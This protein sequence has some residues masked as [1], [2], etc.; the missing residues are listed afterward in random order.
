VFSTT[1]VVCIG[2][3]L[4]V[5]AASMPAPRR[6][7]ALG[8][9][10]WLLVA[11]GLGAFLVAT[12]IEHGGWVAKGTPAERAKYVV[13]RLKAPKEKNILLIDGG[14]YAARGVSERALQ[15]A[16]RKL[17]Y[18]V[19]VVHM[20]MGA[21][22]HFERQ[23]LYRRIVSQLGPRT[24]KK[25]RWIYLAEVHKQY[26]S[27][28]LAQFTPNAD[29]ARAE[30]YMTPAAAWSALNALNSE[31]I[32]K[33]K[34]PLK[35]RLAVLRNAL[36]RSFN[37]GIA[38]RL[39]NSKKVRARSGYA[40]HRASKR[41]RFRGLDKLLA[42]ARKPTAQKISPW[43][44]EQRAPQ[45]REIWGEYLDR[46][47]YFGVPS[48]QPAQLAYITSFCKLSKR[49]CISPRDLT[50]LRQL[51]NRKHWKDRGHLSASGSKI[52]TQWLAKELRSTGLLAR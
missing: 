37:A 49:K 43:L 36:A 1:V 14:S 45:E 27:S 33:E 9:V 52:Y 22:N 38:S 42:E 32:K 12:C 24:K 28:P 19:R 4:L 46:W 15:H 8:S 16:L 2:A 23:T 26:D 34:A 41:F 47:V 31:H 10:V 35:L 51:N 21:A 17:G 50:L 29:T 11:L 39:V 40:A 44:F 20:A 30:D 3:A 48:T 13:K 25:Q 7:G 5:V 18:S 6:P